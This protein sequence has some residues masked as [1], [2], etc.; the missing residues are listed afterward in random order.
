MT[1]ESL[2]IWSML[3]TW[4]SGLGAF[5]AV[6]FALYSNKPRL[7]INFRGQSK[8]EIANQRPVNAHISHVYH[9]IVGTPKS[10][11]VSF[12]PYRI[13]LDNNAREDEYLDKTVASG[14]FSVIHL[15]T[16][17]LYKS[18]IK[19]CNY[20]KIEVPK[21]MPK[22][23]ICIRLSSGKVYKMDALLSFYSDVQHRNIDK[24]E[25]DIIS[26][27]TLNIQRNFPSDERRMQYYSQTLERYMLAY[28]ADIL[29]KLP[30]NKSL[31]K[32]L[33]VIHNAWRSRFN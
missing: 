7:K 32:K 13:L 22:L 15:N 11:F 12:S 9:E 26:L 6:L 24:P 23:K 18:Y 31:T 17:V 16:D 29:W 3:G 2:G 5:S 14:E 19:Q 20:N 21:Y 25:Q 30:K 10:R 1:D 27:E 28:K 4:F 33:R 8:L